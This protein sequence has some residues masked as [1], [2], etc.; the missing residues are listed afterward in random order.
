MHRC[1]DQ[2]CFPGGSV[3]AAEYF[4]ALGQAT[5]FFEANLPLI[6]IAAAL[7]SPASRICRW[8][9]ETVLS[10]HRKQ[11]KLRKALFEN[12]LAS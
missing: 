8:R 11:P 9:S 7:A 1:P 10:Q 6:D 3:G 5:L 2:I 12:V 4:S